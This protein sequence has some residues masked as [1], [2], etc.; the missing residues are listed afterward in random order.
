MTASIAFRAVWPTTGRPQLGERHEPAFNTTA[1][2]AK[3]ATIASVRD[4][5]R[6]Q[7]KKSRGHEASI[8]QISAWR[9]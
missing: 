3:A 9:A 7:Q 1:A 4:D 8:R 5:Q 2:R 6:D